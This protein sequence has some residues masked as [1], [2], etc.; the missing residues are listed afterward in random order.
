MATTYLGAPI[1]HV[2]GHGVSSQSA[3]S[4]LARKGSTQAAANEQNSLHLQTAKCLAGDGA[5]DIVAS[6]GRVPWCPRESWPGGS[7]LFILLF[8]A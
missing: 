7:S 8:C 3:S 1:L 6:A 2:A 4:E 5:L